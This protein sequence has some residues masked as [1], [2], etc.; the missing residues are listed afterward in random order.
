MKNKICAVKAFIFRYNVH[1]FLYEIIKE[2]S[3]EPRSPEAS[4]TGKLVYSQIFLSNC[5]SVEADSNRKIKKL[6][7]D[8]PQ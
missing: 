6:K 1:I 3:L 8:Q 2:S 4:V 7:C 5:C